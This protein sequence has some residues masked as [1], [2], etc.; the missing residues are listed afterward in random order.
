MRKSRDASRV[1]F[2]SSLVACGV[3]AGSGCGVDSSGTE[4]SRAPAADSVTS[5]EKAQLRV[6][7]AVDV[8]GFADTAA[9]QFHRSGVQLSAA[10]KQHRLE[11]HGG[12]VSM[13]R[14]VTKAERR[15]LLLARARG[16]ASGAALASR[17]LE[18]ETTS[19]GRRGYEC[20]QA[21]VQADVGADGEAQRVF[22]TCSERWTNRAQNAEVAFDF[23]A[24]P[25]GSGDLVVTLRARVDG[26]A[27]SVR[28][29]SGDEGLR[30]VTAKGERFRF[31]HGAFIDAAGVRTSVPARFRDGRITLT[32][33]AAVVDGSSYP[34]VLDPIVGPDLGTDEPVLQPS[35]SGIEPEVASNGTDSLVVFSDFQR[36]R[37]VRADANGSVLDVNWLDL[38]RD[39]ILQFRPM[40]AFGGGH[41]L[42]T[43][44]QDDG[45]STSIWG[46]LLN[47]DG[48]FVGP[49]NF[50][51]SSAEGVDSAVVWNGENFVVGWG[52]YGSAPGVRIAFVGADGTLVAGSER[53]VSPTT[54]AFE[55]RI[56]VGANTMVVAWEEQPPND[57]S[58]LSIGATRLSQ[59]GTVLDPSG[60]R[61][62]PSE[63]FQQD[64]VVASDGQRFL[65]AWRESE[66]ATI[67]GALID[68]A[69]TTTPAF[70]ISRSQSDVSR[71]A[72]AFDGTQYLV[73]WQAQ[74]DADGIV[75]GTAVTPEGVVLGTGD[76]RLGGVAVRTGADPTGLTWNGSHFLLV[77]DGIRT[78]PDGFGVYG[79]DGS[80]VAPDL[81]ITND[82]LAFS[83]LPNHQYSPHTVWNG[84]NYVVSW[85]DER[86]GRSFDQSTARA[87]RITSAGRV[88]DPDGIPLTPQG[89]YVNSL[90]SNGDR[91]SIVVWPTPTGIGQ[92]RSLAANGALGLVRSLTARP[93]SS[94]PEV[95]SDGSSFLATF[96]RANANGTRTDLFGTFINNNGNPGPLFPIQRGVDSAGSLTTVNG[97][98]LAL[99]S[100]GGVSQMVT[101]TADGEVSSPVLAPENPFITLRAA[102]SDQNALVT[103]VTSSGEVQ[104][105]LFANGALQG[106]PLSISPTSDGFPPTVA[107]DGARY[108]VAWATD[109]DTERPMIRSV[110]VDGT[111]GS[112]SQ[113]ADEMCEAP[114]LAS[115]GAQQML[116]TCF[117]FSDHYRVS[118]I[119]TRLIDTSVDAPAAAASESDN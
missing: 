12:V 24:R 66:S 96:S 10:G 1:L 53:Q 119:T 61:V 87:V 62:D 116:L 64:P 34:A 56:A 16:A 3:V 70:P 109:Y 114:E 46:R 5:V 92:V 23:P 91:R 101:V 110:E 40:V 93:I 81:T 100:V 72:V 49:A 32:V 89:A 83:R 6:G 82:A 55:Q 54:S 73:A 77:Y 80:I 75:V 105:S 112:A 2:S 68:S 28:A 35:S 94:N 4:A 108:W 107:F 31:G 47:P 86:D 48:T 113:V 78:Q 11:M 90:A 52:G 45:T 71:P 41:Y 39:G 22:A 84:V 59:D 97:T 95:A 106:S 13:Q 50:Q 111:L 33:P 17:A 15:R 74:T 8:R 58:H 9:L 65:V 98:Y 21:E 18:L 19:V 103:W 117:R 102:S 104:A 43:W 38:G 26:S 88:R 29:E 60:I 115:N 51:I 69:G 79:I 57:Y 85:T 14:V 36:I 76:T 20:I 27:S 118:R 25:S 44:W 42:V 37:A 30:L 63:T 7:A 99:F 67:K